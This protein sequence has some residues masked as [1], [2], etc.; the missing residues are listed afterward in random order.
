MFISKLS[1]R[2][3]GVKQ[4]MDKKN[5]DPYKLPTAFF[6]DIPSSNIYIFWIITDLK[7]DFKMKQFF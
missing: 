3:Q 5:L 2:L 6:P 7:I 4:I 1:Q